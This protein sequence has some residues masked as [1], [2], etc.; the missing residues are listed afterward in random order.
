MLILQV[1]HKIQS[2]PPLL[3]VKL[4]Q[5]PKMLSVIRKD[6]APQAFCVSFKVLMVLI[7]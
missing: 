6:W 5:V 4:F 2:G 1:E 3:D 7:C